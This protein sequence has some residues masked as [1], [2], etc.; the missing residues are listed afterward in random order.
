LLLTF[1]PGGMK[2]SMQTTCQ[3]D[4]PFELTSCSGEGGAVGGGLTGFLGYH[5]D[6]VGVEL[7]MGG[8]YDQSSPTLNWAASSTDP[9]LGPDPARTEEFNVRRVGGFAI[10]RIRLTL[11]GEKLRFSVAGG[12][13][14]SYRSMLLTRDTTAIANRAF[15]DAFVP[16]A[17]G[18][19]SPALSLEPSL[20]Y[21]IGRAT[22]LSLG[23]SVLVESPRAFDQIPTTTQVGGNSLGPSGLTTPAY[24]L[25][26]GTQVFVGPT[27]GMMF[28]P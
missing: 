5:W 3:G 18:Y 20:Q 11:Q 16:D 28:G 26:T 21:R 1:L 27:L 23:F 9:G 12:V 19:L 8:Q 15:R 25:A 22:A 2:H 13:G 14:I 10:A 24:Q 6:P 4:K 7:F 17:E